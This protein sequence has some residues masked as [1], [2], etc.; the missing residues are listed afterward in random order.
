VFTRLE[1][2]GCKGLHFNLWLVFVGRLEAVSSFGGIGRVGWEEQVGV[3]EFRIVLLWLLVSLVFFRL[4]WLVLERGLV[5][6]GRLE[7]V[8]SG[9][10]ISITAAGHECLCVSVHH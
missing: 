2:S 9:T 3:V 4:G 1:V 8:V 10:S 7:G 5:L 6:V